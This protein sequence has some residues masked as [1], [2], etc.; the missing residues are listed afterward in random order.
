VL[1]PAD[2]ADAERQLGR[3]PR[4]LV[5]VAA[6]CRFGRP[7]VLEQAPYDADGVPFPT[8]YWLSCPVLVEAVGRLEGAGGIEELA[9]ELAADPRLEADRAAAEARVRARRRALAADGPRLDGGA[10]LAAGLAGEAPGGGLKCLHAH[11]AVA[12][13]D[14]PYALGARVL[15]LAGAE[16]PVCCLA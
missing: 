9:A 11:A 10:A 12:L 5:R 8:L 13:A 14:P 4:A 3:P 6:R 1:A 7:A 16:V 2:L 15:A